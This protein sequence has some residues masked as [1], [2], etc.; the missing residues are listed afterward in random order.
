MFSKGR[1]RY[2]VRHRR[3]SGR[4]IRL[5]MLIVGGTLLF[6]GC[7]LLMGGF[8]AQNG[9]FV[10]IGGAYVLVGLVVLGVRYA[11]AAYLDMKGE[12]RDENTL[13]AKAADLDTQAE[14]QGARDSPATK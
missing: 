13:P 8:G 10:R 3:R 4:G 14:G 12:G 7:L 11:Y 2:K 6:L 5:I 1:R 9:A